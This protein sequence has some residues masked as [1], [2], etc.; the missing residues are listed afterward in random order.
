MA[1]PKDDPIGFVL[2]VKLNPENPTFH[3]EAK[4]A[5]AAID[6]EIVRE[7]AEIKSLRQAREIIADR[8]GL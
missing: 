1:N 7:Q 4:D 5:L 8:H 6:A 2:Q 3:G